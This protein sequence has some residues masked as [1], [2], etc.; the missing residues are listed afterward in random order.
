MT[1]ELDSTDAQV[2]AAFAQLVADEP[3]MHVDAHS[4]IDAG[5]RTARRRVINRSIA[6]AAVVVI[7][8][9]TFAAV[10]RDH[11]DRTPTNNAKPVPVTN[12]ALRL[13]ASHGR[14]PV[15]NG[16]QPQSALDARMIAIIKA[17]SPSGFAF[18]FGG[19]G[20]NQSSVDGTADDGAG[21]GRVYV[22]VSSSPGSMTREPCGDPEFAAG[23]SCRET[24]LAGDAIL[25]V[26]GL[27]DYQGIQTYEIAL[28]HADGSGVG[29]EV[30]N[31][32]VPPLPARASSERL[33]AL[34]PTVTRP[35]PIYGAPHIAAIVQAVDTSVHP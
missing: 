24:H 19:G 16:G 18:D 23:V 14:V 17:N 21:P 8:T 30:G 6:V 9:A 28:T 12:P 25:S 15:G 1:N 22:W 3:P 29:A 27:V 32:T 35:S 4:A 13:T 20:T 7:A 2:R 11:N 33:R 5:R 26:R 31:F 10:T 34:R